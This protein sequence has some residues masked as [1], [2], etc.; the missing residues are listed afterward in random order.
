MAHCSNC[1]AILFQTFL[2]YERET[3]AQKWQI[4]NLLM[5]YLFLMGYLPVQYCTSLEQP[6]LRTGAS[7]IIMLFPVNIRYSMRLKECGSWHVLPRLTSEA[8]KVQEDRPIFSCAIEDTHPITTTYSIQILFLFFIHIWI[9]IY[10]WT[11]IMPICKFKI[12]HSLFFDDIQL[13]QIASSGLSF[14]MTGVCITKLLPGNTVWCGY[15]EAHGPFL[16]W[17]CSIFI[18]QAFDEFVRSHYTIEEFHNLTT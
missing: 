13:S 14:F 6:I 4:Y 18:T 10:R 12:I 16:I 11:Y 5:F 17:S 3:F 15:Q 9:M 1:C 7:C 2:L 8:L